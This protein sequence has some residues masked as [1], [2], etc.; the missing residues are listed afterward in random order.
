MGRLSRLFLALLLSLSAASGASGQNAPQPQLQPR[1]EGPAKAPAPKGADRQV[2][3]EVQVNDRSGATVCGLQKQDFTLLDDKQPQNILSFRA[4][5]GGAAS[6]TDPVEI[7]LVIDA[8]NSSFQAVASERDQ[9]RKFLL[10]NSGKLAEPVSL[11]IFS[12]AGADV[13][14]GSSRDG[15]ALATLLDQ[16]EVGLRTITRSQGYWGA[17]ER[18]EMSLKAIRSLGQYEG[19]QPGRKLMIWMSPGWPLLSGPN[20]PLSNK[21]LQQYFNSIVEFSAGFRQARVTIYSL[22]PLGTSDFGRSR[23]YEAFVKGVTSPS[24]T[25]PGNLGLQVLA[26]QT[27]GRVFT[28]TNDITGAIADC[29]ADADAY[30]VLSFEGALADR[31]NEYHAIG[32]TVDR[33]G[34]KA[35]TRTGYYAQR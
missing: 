11:V 33:P 19:T 30:Y 31:A 12:D 32:V 27:G 28:S 5:D 4:V 7:V 34:V 17:V 25:V 29:A 14:N 15:N 9:I 22:D 1:P 2:T 16:K 20:V 10:R 18:L 6:T 3:I 21:E 8:V 23:H 13:Q 26:V 35:R 24:R